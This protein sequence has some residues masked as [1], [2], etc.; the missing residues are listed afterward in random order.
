MSCAMLSKSLPLSGLRKALIW[1]RRKL[2]QVFAKRPSSF[3]YDPKD[4]Y[5]HS[6]LP[7]SEVSADRSVATGPFIPAWASYLQDWCPQVTDNLANLQWGILLPLESLH[8]PSGRRPLPQ[9]R[10]GGLE[11]ERWLGEHG[12]RSKIEG[13]PQ[14]TFPQTMLWILTAQWPFPLSSSTPVPFQGFFFPPSRLGFGTGWS[15]TSPRM[16]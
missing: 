7:D 10:E 2:N 13:R 4:K 14:K 12:V 15:N 1:K 8:L 6:S 5:H 11:L 16:L 3:N 9:P